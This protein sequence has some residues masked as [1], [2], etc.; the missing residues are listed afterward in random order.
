MYSITKRLNFCYG[1]RLLAHPGECAQLHG[2]NGAIEVE[3]KSETLD[4]LGMV[5]DLGDIGKIVKELVDKEL[6][7]C[8]ILHIDDPLVPIL[9]EAGESLRIMKNN[10]TAE[11]IAKFVFDALKS[12]DLPIVAVRIW[13]SDTSRAEYRE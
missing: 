9:Q 2:H 7:H 3:L 5:Y 12:K 1:H 8:L 13:E 6:D 11:N 4:K 10:P